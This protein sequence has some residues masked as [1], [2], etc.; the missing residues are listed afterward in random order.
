[1]VANS[2]YHGVVYEFSKRNMCFFFTNV[3]SRDINSD[4]KLLNT[5]FTDE[6]KN[7]WYVKKYGTKWYFKYFFPPFDLSLTNI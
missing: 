4:T 1:M 5:F 2:C 6:N 7:I 3:A